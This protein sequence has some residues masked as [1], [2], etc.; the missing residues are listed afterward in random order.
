MAKNSIK[1]REKLAD[2]LMAMQASLF[3]NVTSV[4]LI[5]PIGFFSVS[6]YKGERLDLMNFFGE[7]SSVAMGGIFVCYLATLFFVMLGRRAAIKIYN[8]LYADA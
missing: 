8:S 5:A 7:N 6:I 4:V 1:A 3:V 2:S